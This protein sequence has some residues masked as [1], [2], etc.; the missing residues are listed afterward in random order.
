MHAHTNIY[1]YTYVYIYTYIYIHVYIY[2]CIYLFIYI[3]IYIYIW[4]CIYIY[5][6]I[7]SAHARAWF[8]RWRWEAPKRGAVRIRVAASQEYVNTYLTRRLPELV[9]VYVP[10]SRF[11]E[12]AKFAGSGVWRVLVSTYPE[13]L[14]TKHLE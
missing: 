8:S 4:I 10:A 3:Y 9:C 5:K 2:I 13:T 11:T 14:V 7:H 6:H 12:V 1:V